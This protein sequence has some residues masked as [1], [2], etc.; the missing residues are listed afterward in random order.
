MVA[1][2]CK[3][4]QTCMD[5]ICGEAECK[6]DDE[7]PAGLSC[8]NYRCAID[9]SAMSGIGQ[10]DCEIATLFFEFDSSELTSPMRD[11]IESNYDCLS[12]R[13]GRVVLEG[14]CD[15]FGTTE[16]NMALGE[17]RA[18]GVSKIMRTLGMES[19]KMRV[20]SKGEEEATGGTEDGRSNDRKVEFK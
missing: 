12:K 13:G 7:C 2:D 4:G 16:Y 19:G 1:G 9:E 6:K 17:R 20:I 3:E 15:S 18:R 14:H 8:V 5:G 10:G 11:T